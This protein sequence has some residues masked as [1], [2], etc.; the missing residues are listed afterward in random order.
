LA[1]AAPAT[2]VVAGART[3]VQGQIAAVV[4]VV[5]VVVAAAAAAAAAYGDQLLR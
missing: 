4:V 2:A 5:V 3:P 1:V